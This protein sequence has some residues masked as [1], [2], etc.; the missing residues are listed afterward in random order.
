MSGSSGISNSEDEGPLSVD[1]T[2]KIPTAE[3]S[4]DEENLPSFRQ[5]ISSSEVSDEEETLQDFLGNPSS[6]RPFHLLKRARKQAREFDKKGELELAVKERIR[7]LAYCRLVYGD[8]HWQLALAYSKLGEAYL[9][10]KGFT[11]QALLHATRGRD[12]LLQ[13]EAE[14]YR[15][16]RL[17]HS[18]DVLA[19]MEH[20]YYVMGKANFLMGEFRK[21][22]QAFKKAEISAKERLKFEDGKISEMYVK[23]MDYLGQVNIYIDHTLYFIYVPW[24][25]QYFT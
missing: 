25:H 12:K 2:I 23:I 24:Y 16:T 10:R 15:S 14:E 17:S 9:K 11:Q 3:T 22:E 8:G 21:A 18:N 5:K 13:G 19:T 20:V 1:K 4:E 7:S 6:S